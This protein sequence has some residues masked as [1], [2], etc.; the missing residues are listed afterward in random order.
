MRFLA[1][2]VLLISTACRSG[3]DLDLKFDI[4]QE[5]LSNGLKILFIEDH[6]APVVSYQTWVRAGSVDEKDG[7]TG[8]AHLFE[9]LMFKGTKTH[10]P[11]AF[12]EQFEAKGSQVNA[13][14]TRDYTVYYEVLPSALLPKAIELEADRL[15]GLNLDQKLLNS[16]RLVVLEE[17][18]LRVENSPEG[19]LQEAIWALSFQSHPYGNPVIGTTQDLLTLD[20]ERLVAFYDTYYQPSN[21]TL[22]VS[23]D[24]NRKE[25][26][27]LIR[28]HYGAFQKKKKPIRTVAREP[29]QTGERRLIIRE[30]LASERFARAYHIPA[31]GESDSYALDVLS[32]ILFAGRSSRA[33]R[34]LVEEKQLLLSIGGTALTPAHP[35]LFV[36]SGMLRGQHRTEE[37][38][39]ALDQLLG[40]LE[41]TSPVTPEEI[42][43]AI[44]QLTV[45][46]FDGIRTPHGL[47]Q[48]IG[49]IDAILGDP[50]LYA[51]EAEHYS[52]VTPADVTRVAR[53]YL[54]PNN[55]SVV[56]LRPGGK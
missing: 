39:A 18:R 21:I 3:S 26:L 4:K 20:I 32:N 41:T 16:E 22:L 28:K 48:L 52:R 37:A 27:A 47:G 15:R 29:E 36:I 17:R 33:H 54:Q 43:T 2:C 46:I 1:V 9:H 19:K 24:F 11:G 55:R 13:F 14:T 5:T 12:F 40:E 38:E 45:Q 42:K 8:L 10:G 23:G 49:T 30:E 25:T 6:S 50:E 56:I 53:E 44:R 31:A 51:D 34:R 7:G 35:G